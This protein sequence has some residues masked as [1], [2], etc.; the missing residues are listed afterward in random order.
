MK[1]ARLVLLATAVCVALVLPNCSPVNTSTFSNGTYHGTVGQV[2]VISGDSYDYT[3][4][5]TTFSGTYEI[6]GSV[7]IFTTTKINGT[8]TGLEQSTTF[9]FTS[10]SSTISLSNM[11]NQ[12]S[13]GCGM[14]DDT[15]TK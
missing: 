4:T 6:N 2:L 9:D 5:S 10:T 3:Y 11:R 15:F 8:L 13:G 1:T 7:V 12:V 14:A